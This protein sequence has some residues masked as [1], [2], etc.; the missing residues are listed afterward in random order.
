MARGEPALRHVAIVGAGIGGLTAA[1]ALSARG[2]A[3][4]LF[5]RRTGFEEAGAGIQLSPNASRVLI[6]LGLGPALRR[7]A[8]EPSRVAIRAS[9]SGAAIGEIALGAVMRERFGAPYLVIHRRD[10]QR[11]LLDGVRSQSAI[12][13]L[14][15]RRVTAIAEVAGGVGLTLERGGGAEA[16]RFDVAVGADGVWSTVRGAMGDARA[17]VYRGYVA[18]R[19]TIP[20]AA[21]PPE[22]AAVETGLWLGARSHVVHYPLDGGRLL[23]IVAFEQR[24]EPVE[25]WSA[26]G[27]PDALQRVFAGVAPPLAGLLRQ[28]RDWQLWSLFDLPAKRMARGRIALLGD[29]AHPVLP[30]LAQGGALAIEDAAA[31]ALALSDADAVIPAALRR[32]AAERLSR[33]RRVQRVARRNGGT[34]HAGPLVAKARDLA[35]RRL[36]PSGMATRYAWLYGWRPA[37]DGAPA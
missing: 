12:R 13:I 37:P 7:A 1:L 4:T 16:G 8:S 26:P 29:A 17:P 36:G 23:N 28:P 14:L 11:I 20:I 18:W 15:G 19:A 24:A 27:D 21:A 9:R 22:L 34:F 32:Y 31:L 30:F 10:L 5:E 6:Q 33:V 25:G 2:W 35:I 3:V